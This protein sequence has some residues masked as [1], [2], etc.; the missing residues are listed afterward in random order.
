[1]SDLFFDG[2]GDD[3]TR[4]GIH[5]LLVGV[6]GYPYLAEPNARQ[7]SVGPPTFGLRQL[8]S[9]GPSALMLARTLRRHCL[10]AIDLTLIPRAGDTLPEADRCRMIVADVQGK[11]HFRIFDAAGNRVIDVG[12]DDLAGKA[13]QIA[14][15]RS[16]LGR[17]WD[18]PKPSRC[19]KDSIISAVGSIVGHLRPAGLRLRTCR[20]LVSPMR[21]GRG[22][23]VAR[24]ESLPEATLE[25]LTKAVA[26]WRDDA[27][28]DPNGIMLFYFVGHGL[29]RRLGRYEATEQL[30]LLRDFGRPDTPTLHHTFAAQDLVRALSRQPGSM[31]PSKQIFV[32]DCCRD[33]LGALDRLESDR[34][35][36]LLDYREEGSRDDRMAAQ[37]YATR[38][39][40]EAHGIG[41]RASVVALALVHALRGG[42]AR[43]SPGA[44]A[45]RA[46]RWQV[47]LGSLPAVLNY[48]GAKLARITKESQ[49]VENSGISEKLVLRELPGPPRVRFSL[50]VQPPCPD[51]PPTL[52]VRTWDGQQTFSSKPGPPDRGG[53][54]HVSLL[55]GHVVLGA[56]ADAA[57]PHYTDSFC[58][59][60]LLQTPFPDED[61]PSCRIELR[62]RQAASRDGGI[63]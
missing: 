44:V 38:P 27:L 14:Q 36:L 57:D 11:L 35:S 53:L 25:S 31:L 61:T 43:L 47:P 16:R 4:Q 10:G 33:Q 23:G 50:G 62:P 8:A 18:V 24:A 2:R 26:A 60:C 13:S 42:G 7:R 28:D 51:F 5:A 1:V 9:A 12:E 41:D 56:V 6:G 63:T 49:T 17:S 46:A 21:V 40:F 55:G 15:L 58:P 20:V 32:F 29:Q 3:R 59:P 52:V 48:F 19:R 37:F 39:G 54:V 30:C 45:N 22:S 34:P